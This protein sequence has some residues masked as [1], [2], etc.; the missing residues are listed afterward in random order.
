MLRNLITLPLRVAAFTTRVGVLV[1]VDALATG[2]TVADRL[3]ELAVPRP[4]QVATPRSVWSVEVVSIPSQTPPA[5]PAEPAADEQAAPVESSADTGTQDG[6]ASSVEVDEPWEGYG[7]MNAHDV[8]H[9]L[10][11]STTEEAVMVERYERSHG[12]RKTVLAAAERRLRQPAGAGS[13]S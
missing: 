3:I 4:K 7:G 13:P 1:A 12:E 6:A 10:A 11:A 5:E 8:I 2:M 9:R